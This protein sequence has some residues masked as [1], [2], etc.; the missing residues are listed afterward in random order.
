[1]PLDV[2]A[3]DEALLR[4]LRAPGPDTFELALRALRDDLEG[5]SDAE[6]DRGVPL[7]P[8]LRRYAKLAGKIPTTNLHFHL[9]DEPRDGRL[10]FLHE[11][12]GVFS[13]AATRDAEDPAV[14][15]EDD[16]QWLREGERLSRFLLEYALYEVLVQTE[17][18]GM[19]RGGPGSL[20]RIVDVIP[21]LPLARWHHPGGMLSFH[22][23]IG[24]LAMMFHEPSGTQ[25]LWIAAEEDGAILRAL[26]P[27]VHWSIPPWENR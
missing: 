14:W 24:G 22:A 17:S 23:A 4:R 8:P 7:P 10:G 20:P 6:L 13:V 18:A 11:E 27:L 21:E 25:E 3:I 19:A 12:Q 5:F 26:E 9:P 2:R 1:M 16:G 15:L